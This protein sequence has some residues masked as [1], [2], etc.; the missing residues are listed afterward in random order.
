MQP[1]KGSTPNIVSLETGFCDPA[2]MK[3]SMMAVFWQRDGTRIDLAVR[4]AVAVH[5][6][7]GPRIEWHQLVV[8]RPSGRTQGPVTIVQLRDLEELGGVP[9]VLR[10]LEH[11][12]AGRLKDAARYAS[13]A[14]PRWRR[15]VDFFGGPA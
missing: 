13:A 4:D 2:F 9:E 11:F 10:A 6:G 15:L 12:E 8:S 7:D 14:G 5:A 3:P 1:P